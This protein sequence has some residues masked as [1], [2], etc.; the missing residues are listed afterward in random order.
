MPITPSVLAAMSIRTSESLR[1]EDLPSAIFYIGSIFEYYDNAS[2]YQTLQSVI[3]SIREC[4][5]TTNA[6]GRRAMSPFQYSKQRL[7]TQLYLAARTA[8]VAAQS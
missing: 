3:G 1:E 4:L 8:R 7:E 5:A 2:I 6:T